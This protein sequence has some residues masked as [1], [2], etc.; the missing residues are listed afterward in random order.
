[1]R[2][3]IDEM[4]EKF[5]AE[6]K[7]RHERDAAIRNSFLRLKNEYPKLPESLIVKMVVEDLDEKLSRTV[8]ARRLECMKLYVPKKYKV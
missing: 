5:N 4:A 8:V 6:L 2:N 1:M 7:R 3:I